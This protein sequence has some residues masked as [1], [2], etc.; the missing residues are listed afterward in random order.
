MLV[1]SSGTKRIIIF[2]IL[3]LSIYLGVRMSG[4]MAS[5][6]PK[7]VVETKEAEHVF[8][9][10]IHNTKTMLNFTVNDFP[11]VVASYNDIVTQEGVRTLYHVGTRN[12][13]VSVIEFSDN[14]YNDVI[15]GLREIPGLENEKTETSPAAT[16]S[17]IDIDSHIEQNHALLRR[18][19]ERLTNQYLTTREISELHKEISNIQTKI[20]SL[21]TLKSEK[22]KE[23][24]L[25]MA[26]IRSDT[27]PRAPTGITRY[28]NLS[29]FVLL[30]FVVVTICAILIYFGIEFLTKL[31]A[32]L[33]V[34]SAKRSS[35]YGSYGKSSS[36]YGYGRKTVRK[37]KPKPRSE[38]PE[39]DTE[40]E[41]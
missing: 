36:Y 31:A 6:P 9:N 8:N 23:N 26:V 35:R 19:E 21:N 3:A 18:Y 2:V 33:G 38:K 27:G 20:D 1:M 5:V 41:N 29:L 22:E 32:I 15:S 12:N 16:V 4:F 25:V 17:G 11:E 34:R 30:S 37:R 40:K 28:I 7:Q 24:N 13:I 10:A 39:D 14:L